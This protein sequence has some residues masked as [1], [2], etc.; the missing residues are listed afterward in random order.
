MNLRIHGLTHTPAHRK[1]MTE[2]LEACERAGID[3]PD[4]VRA[5]FNA[6]R[7]VSGGI[8][9]LTAVNYEENSGSLEISAAAIKDFLRKNPDVKVLRFTLDYY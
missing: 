3:P 7:N 4:S 2:V 6:E 9:V 8:D 5:F 1:A